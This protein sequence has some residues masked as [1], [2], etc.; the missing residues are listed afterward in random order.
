MP[1]LIRH[2]SK[3][4]LAGNKTK[5][6]KEYIGRVNSK[7]ATLSLALMHSP[8][9]WEEPGQ[10]PKFSEYTLVLKGRLQIESKKGFMVVGAGQAVIVRKGEWVRY[11][12]P[13]SGGAD[14]VA[15]CL[16]AFS[17]SKAHRDST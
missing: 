7:T 13:Y 5:I 6:I 2:P 16:P 9:G 1:R 10:R 15:V 4:K 12:T 8:V 3:I 17:L 11:R 14:Y